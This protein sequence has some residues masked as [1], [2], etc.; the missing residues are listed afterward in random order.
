[1]SKDTDKSLFIVSSIPRFYQQLLGGIADYRALGNR[2]IKRI[3][4]AH[5]FRQVDKVRELSRILINIPIKEYQLIAQYYLVWCKCREYEYPLTTLE[6]IIEQTKTYKTK[7]LF[8]RAA[9]EGFHGDVGTA[10]YFYTEALK[11]S[12]TISEYVDLVRSIA[13]LKST[14]GFHKSALRDLENLIPFIKHTEPRL[15]FDFLNSYAFELGEASRKEEARNIIKHV[16]ASP[17]APAYPE[18]QETAKELK[19]SNRS[20][21][22]VPL[23]KREAVESETHPASKQEQPARVLSFPQLTVAP[24]PKKPERVEPQE[25]GRMTSNE[26]REMILAAVRSGAISESKYNKLMLMLGLV[27]AGPAEKVIDLEDE[28]TLNDLIIEWSHLIGPDILASVLSALRDCE[29]RI[30]QRDILDRMIRI[31]FEQ[32]QVCGITEEE[33]RLTVERKLPQK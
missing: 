22:A 29:D 6:R 14:E 33:W 3:E 1:M 16:L 17:F 4:T 7:A 2:I 21:V 26:K 8:S 18:W 12:P 20:F 24:L 19:E 15:Y 9:F 25:F 30:R 10:I 11:T 28:T 5:A 23:I 13:V 27:K 32:T 31:A